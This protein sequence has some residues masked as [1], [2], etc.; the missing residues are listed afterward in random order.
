M[1]GVL[2]FPRGKGPFPAV[3]VQHGLF[4]NHNQAL[5]RLI[6]SKL[7]SA[8]FAALRFSATGHLPSEGTYQDIL[9]SQ[10]VRDI[11]S[12]LEFLKK[13]PEVNKLRIGIVGHSL[14]AFSSLIF[15]S[16][17]KDIKAVVSIASLFGVARQ[18]S[19]LK[20]RGLYFEYG[21]HVTVWG[22]KLSKNHYADRKLWN[23]KKM[24]ADIHCPLL[25]IHGSGDRTVYSADARKI[26]KLANSPKELKIVRFAGHNFRNAR[27]LKQV[28]ASTVG[29][30]KR[31]LAFREDPVVIAFIKCQDRIL[32]LKRGQLVSTHRGLWAPVGGYLDGQ[33]PLKQAR[34]EVSEET[35][36]KS[37]S[38]KNYRLGKPLRF[39]ER[40]IDRVWLI[41]PI[42]FELKREPRVKLDWEHTDYQWVSIREIKKIRPQEPALKHI[43]KSLELT[44]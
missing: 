29:W 9:A 5:V 40:E 1:T 24:I 33:T 28:I 35:G 3:I 30:F 12:G 39:V 41:S 22:R 7:C 36:I 8:G 42:L 11:Q 19:I 10:F 43:L 34:R 26:Y 32:L 20:R 21:D 23:L 13:Q 6:A 4:V 37:L 16:L 44:D 15:A 38:L 27:H 31:Y 14:G 18:I 17:E 2:H 25:V